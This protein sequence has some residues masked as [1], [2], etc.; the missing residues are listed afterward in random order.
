[1]SN[2]FGMR[3]NVERPADVQHAADDGRSQDAEQRQGDDERASR[4]LAVPAA[5]VRGLLPQGEYVVVYRHG[6]K[7][8]TTCALLLTRGRSGRMLRAVAPGRC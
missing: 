4:A 1:M 8:D 2:A 6:Q 3:S 5:F 7:C